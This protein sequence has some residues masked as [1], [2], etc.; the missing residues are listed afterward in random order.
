MLIEREKPLA[1]LAGL[2]HEAAQGRGSVVIVSG[3]AGIGKSAL[4]RSFMT[5]EQSCRKNLSGGCEALFTP[6]PLGPLQDMA[7]GLDAKVAQLLDASAPQDRLF[8]AVLDAL[9]SVTGCTLMVFEDVHWAD[10]ATL[11]LIKYLGRRVALLPCMLVL[12]F[13][14]DEVTSDHPLS[15]VLGDL[16]SHVTHRIVLE[17]LSGQ[18]V[19]S[20]AR[21]T[22]RTAA[23]L[24]AITGGNP[25]F[26]TEVLGRTGDAEASIPASVRDAV[27][28]RLSRFTA[29]ERRL[30]EVMSIIPGSV[31]P[32][33]LLTLWGDGYPQAVATCLAR[34]VL[35]QEASG[36]MR[37]RH[38]LARKATLDRLSV[39]EQK[40]LHAKVEA[41]MA[42]SESAGHPV[43][44]SARVHHASGAGNAE[45]VLQLAPRAAAEAA[46]LGAHQQAAAHLET[47]L[48][49]VGRAAPE[50]AARLYEDWSYEAGIALAIN[51]AIID[52]RH[53][54]IAIW[55]SLGRADKVGLNLRWLS[56][57][58]WYRGE[59]ALAQKFI[60]E[61]LAELE[62]LSP[63]AE[64]AMLYSATSQ[65]HMLHDRT[66]E[67]I[68]WGRKAMALAEQLGETETRI[69][70]LNNVG[71]SLLFSGRDGG[72]P[73]MELSLELAL[74][75]G[76]HE[77]AARAYTNYGE[78]GVLFRDFELAERI[79]AEGIAFDSS[80]E[81]DSW[82]YYLV[83]RQAQLRMEQGRLREAQTIARGVMG[84]D[85]LTLLMRLPARTVLGRVNAR[86]GEAD[87]KAILDQAL[88]D[89]LATGEQQYIAPA[90]LGLL[91]DAWLRDDRDVAASILA[92][93][94]AMDLKSFDPWERGDVA[95]WWQRLDMAG[96]FPGEGLKVAIPRDLELGGDV[97]G[98][99]EAWQ[100]LG[101]PYEQAA[102]LMMAKDGDRKADLG[103][104]I[105]ILDGMFAAPL[106][107]KARL[108][109]KDLGIAADFIKQ[110]R[111]PYA[112]TRRHPLGL[113]AKEVQVLEL[114]AKGLGNHAIAQRLTR[115]QRTVEHHVSSVL[116]KMNASNRMDVLI[117]LQSEPWLLSQN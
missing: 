56:R 18:A 34:G 94:V 24:H 72:K 31:D 109:A 101:M 76:F 78:Y 77:Q 75:H 104:A 69:H 28:A 108:V 71:A 93:L 65:M 13:R 50:L 105:T 117:R 49:H 25:F 11:D 99:A 92:D 5:S 100:K 87:S 12:T 41:A 70:A 68:A 98:A 33:L 47:A 38:E 3:E 53:K 45:T 89:A 90:R 110:R 54:A 6:R 102:C 26:V 20:L 79:L 15:Q 35:V 106:A 80:H 44:L 22:G 91:E 115:S 14:N 59:S 39:S 111:G 60:A 61:A 9:Q 57:L 67:A 62:A 16:P 85:R 97:R 29:E 52:A 36:L 96:A 30:L 86:L 2:A 66:D 32:T 84:L 4:M 37:F 112:A 17:P 7:S 95:V 46:K 63:S 114:M 103:R 58:H 42:A 19:A 73:Y 107:R 64:L 51:D 40:T 10:K 8:P 113:T 83:G 48:R 82:T 21:A 1:S 74:Q 55:R 43:A 88:A 81:L 116:D 27:W 23:D